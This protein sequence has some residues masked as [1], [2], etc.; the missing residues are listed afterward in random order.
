[1]NEMASSEADG[2]PDGS[3]RRVTSKQRMRAKLSEVKTELRR[4]Q[5]LPIPD[6]GRWLA[7]VIRGHCNYYAVPGNSDAINAFRD[8][9][10]RHWY[11]ALAVPPAIDIPHQA[12][13]LGQPG[14]RGRPAQTPAVSPT[15]SRTGRF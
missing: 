3:W 9:A 8:Q 6:Q 1:M 4:R 14:L 7:S 10:T 15:V 11:W 5:H 12:S 13:R 2:A